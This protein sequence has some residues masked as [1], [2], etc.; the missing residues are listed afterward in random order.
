ML[1]ANRV[2]ENR[3]GDQSDCNVNRVSG[4][5]INDQQTNHAHPRPPYVHAPAEVM[6]D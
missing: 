3:S 1:S 4:Q 2:G 5:N 6:R